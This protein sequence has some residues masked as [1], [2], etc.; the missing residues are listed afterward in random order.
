MLVCHMTISLW[1]DKQTEKISEHCDLAIV[2]AG[3]A[4]AAAAYWLS[5]NKGLKVV[6]LES[7]EAG[8]A[9]SGRNGGFILRGIFAYYKQAVHRYGREMAQWIFNFNE[10]TQSHLIDFIRRHGN[11]FAYNECGSYLLACSLEELQELEE[12]AQ[13]MK[14][15]GFELEYMREDPLDRGFYGCIHNPKDAGVN[16]YEMVKS[17]LDVS[18]AA[19][20]E[21]EQVYEIEKHNGDYL[22]HTTNRK[23]TAGKVLL[24]TNAYLPLLYP[25]YKSLIQPVRGQIIVTRSIKERVL[26]H[27]CYANYG[28]EYF[29]QLPD[30]RF[31]LGGCREPFADAEVGYEDIISADVADALNDYLKDRFPE[32]AGASV[33][34]RWTGT[35][36]F[37]KDGLPIMGQI[38]DH[39]GIYFVAGCNGH[40]MGYSLAMSKLLVEFAINGASPGVFNA[41]R[42]AVPES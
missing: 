18:G 15:D 13:L 24:T 32:V 3:V 11:T 34:Y 22:L 26:D 14:D 25:Q 12:S 27:L 1:L 7:N 23:I 38:E 16:P 29:R 20:Y 19:L 40:G 33:D 21:R 28:Y 31:L 17:L 2:G 9:A 39:D 30:G 10:E 42:L 35:M 5:K 8:S 4:G 6:V 37:T 41:R 36:C